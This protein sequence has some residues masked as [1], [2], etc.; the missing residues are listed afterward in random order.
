[1]TPD[2][3]EYHERLQRRRNKRRDRLVEKMREEVSL[4]R[5]IVEE[6][7][8]PRKTAEPRSIPHAKDEPSCVFL[9]VLAFYLGIAGLLIWC[10]ISAFGEATQ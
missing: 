9:V 3:A 7:K 5:Q 2:E 10:A 6:R 4:L 1:M 8:D